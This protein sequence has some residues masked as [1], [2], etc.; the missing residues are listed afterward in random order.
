[1]ER[2]KEIRELGRGGFGKT[3]LVEDLAENNT[4]VV[5]KV[6][7]SEEAEAAL[8]DDVIHL[9]HLQASVDN[10]EHPNIV[11]Y[12]GHSTFEG[13]PVMI[14]EYV[15]G[16][17][18]RKMI[19]PMFQKR[20]PMELDLALRITMDACTG[21]I[22]AHKAHVF[23]SDI[24]PDNILVRDADGVA[25]L[26]DF[27]ISQFMRTTAAAAAGGTVPYM[28]PEALAGKAAFRADIWSLSVTLY[29]L[30]TGRLPFPLP[31]GNVSQAIEAVKQ[32]ILH[33]DPTPPKQIN[34]KIDERLNSIILRGLEKKVVN[35][36]QKA[37]EMKS[38]LEA[39]VRGED[40]IDVEISKGRELIK[41][42]KEAEAEAVLTEVLQRFPAKAEAYLLLG[43]IYTRELKSVQSEEI[44]R[45]GIATCP[46]HAVLHFNLAMVLNSRKKR[47]EAIGVLEK[48]IQLGLGRL[49]PYAKK[50]L[51]TW[52]EGL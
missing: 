6:P 18:L 37:Q 13:H 38:A 21:L 31:P 7:L 9:A 35:R 16:K 10:M 47:K 17:E 19:G 28:S 30:V 45:K 15:K 8:L 44:L 40:Y 51:P 33:D 27:G 3:L 23:H 22:A 11:R 12:L 32:A 46:A 48:A 14:L 4:R 34:P 41:E 36:F 24:K 39:F 52:T 20:A 29:E 43:E 26:I 50:L 49:A 25:I 1:M 2:F 42:K 5:I